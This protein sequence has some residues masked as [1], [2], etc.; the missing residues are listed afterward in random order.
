MQ[1]KKN[2]NLRCIETCHPPFLFKFPVPKRHTHIDKYFSLNTDL[3][4]QVTGPKH[5]PKHDHGNRSKFLHL[6]SAFVG[7]IDSTESDK[8]MIFPR[9]CHSG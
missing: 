7:H 9:I 8:C 4:K 1:M 2:L 3:L 6:F 5:V